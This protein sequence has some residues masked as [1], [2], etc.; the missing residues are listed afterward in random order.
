MKTVLIVLIILWFNQWY[1]NYFQLYSKLRSIDFCHFWFEK[2]TIKS[3]SCIVTFDIILLCDF[4]RYAK[5]LLNTLCSTFG[6]DFLTTRINPLLLYNRNLQ[7]FTLLGHIIKLNKSR[8]RP[9]Y[10]WVKLYKR[11]LFRCH[12]LK[13]RWQEALRNT[14]IPIFLLTQK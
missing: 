8:V 1:H 6:S 3:F 10:N 5:W 12:G 11:T 14:I 13:N 9:Y 2:Y 4:L 7:T